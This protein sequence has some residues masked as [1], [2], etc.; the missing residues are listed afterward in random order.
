MLNVDE[1]HDKLIAFNNLL[2][3]YENNFLCLYKVLKDSIAYWDDSISRQFYTDIENDENKVKVSYKEL[4]D[5]YLIYKYVYDN[6]SKVSNKINFDLVCRDRLILLFDRYILK[7]TEIVNIYSNLDYSFSL[8]VSSLLSAHENI[9]RSLKRDVSSL[10]N[11]NKEM[12]LN[13]EELEKNIH[14]KSFKTNIEK[15]SETSLRKYEFND[16][17]NKYMMDPAQMSISLRKLVMYKMTI[18]INFENIRE[19]IDSINYSY[20]TSNS[21]ELKNMKLKITEKL[22]V[23]ELIYEHY[24]TIINENIEKYILAENDVRNVFEQL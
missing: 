12:L 14:L 3:E 6:Y 17:V 2:E 21:E 18:D 9:F 13:I 7:L 24:I 1:L 20:L 10:K 19:I 11:M 8:S 22:K 15:M 23:I 16:L 5:L 4:Y